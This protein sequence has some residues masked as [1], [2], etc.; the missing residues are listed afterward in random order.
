[1]S[2]TQFNQMSATLINQFR[3]DEVMPFI[4]ERAKIG[5]I[6]FA[7]ELNDVG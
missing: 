4:E 5:N 3:L 2:G 1:M 7:D 6:G